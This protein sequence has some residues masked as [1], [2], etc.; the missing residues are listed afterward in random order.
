MAEIFRRM[1]W[2]FIVS[3]AIAYAFFL[4]VGSTITSSAIDASRI[5]VARDSL[6]QGAHNL[7]GMVMVHSSCDELSVHSEQLS[8][9]TYLL[10]FT[11]WNEP[12]IASCSHEDTPRPFRAL[13]FAPSTGVYFT[14]TLDDQPLGISVIP[15]IEHSY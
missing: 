10:Q 6:S 13:V 11:T 5:I 8:S 2:F 15:S 1:L 12:S 3:C 4:L 7:S 14:A 9:D